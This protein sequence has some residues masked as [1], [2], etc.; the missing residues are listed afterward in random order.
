MSSAQK[1]I[2][3]DSAEAICR[4]VS[5]G[6]L[7]ECYDL[8]HDTLQSIKDGHEKAVKCCYDTTKLAEVIATAYADWDVRLPQLATR[9]SNSC[10]AIILRARRGSSLNT[11]YRYFGLPAPCAHTAVHLSLIHI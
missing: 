11:D 1:K 2:H 10:E 6:D 9:L 5:L 8:T 4:A 3:P 7:R